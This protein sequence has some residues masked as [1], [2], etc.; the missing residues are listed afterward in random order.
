MT[1]CNTVKHEMPYQSH[2]IFSRLTL[3]KV[4]YWFCRLMVKFQR[5]SS[6][7]SQSMAVIDTF[8][9]LNL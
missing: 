2:W 4:Y 9:S 3:D 8:V 1:S 7:K 5:M 6:L